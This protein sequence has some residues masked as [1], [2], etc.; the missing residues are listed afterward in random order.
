MTPLSSLGCLVPTLLVTSSSTLVAAMS[1]DDDIERDDSAV[2]STLST[3][4]IVFRR[5]SPIPEVVMSG[6][7][8][9]SSIIEALRAYQRDGV[10]ND[11]ISASMF[12]CDDLRLNE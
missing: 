5:R 9:C 8:R 1:A 12:S 3:S 7:S 11:V 2:G 10:G 4:A 6:V